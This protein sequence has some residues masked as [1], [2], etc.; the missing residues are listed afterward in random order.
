MSEYY[1]MNDVSFK[2]QA[3]ER[4]AR[5]IESMD[6][7][8]EDIYKDKGLKGLVEIEGVGQGMAEKIEEFIKTGKIKE[9]EKLK[10]ECPVDL[11]SLTAVE[12]LG[13]KKI[14][15]L[16]EKLG[17]KTIADLKE[18]A[19]AGKIRELPRFGPKVEENILSGI[20][21]AAAGHG[22]FLLGAI[23]PL[24]RKIEKRIAEL[25]Y[26]SRAVAAGSIRRFKETIGDIDILTISSQPGKVME[27]FCEMPEVEK[28]IAKGDT[29]SS[30]RLDSGVN[31]DIR[32]VPPESFGA[33]LQYFTGGK[34]HNIELRK[35]AQDKNLKLN[36]YGIFKGKKQVAGKT[37][38][39]VY[40]FLG[41]KWMEPELRENMGE[42]EASQKDQLPKLIE[43]K[44]ILGDLQ[45]HSDWSD[46]ENSITEMAKEASQIGYKYIAITDHTLD[47][48]IAG[49]LD[50]KAILKYFA[51][52][53]K[54]DKELKGIRI[55]KGLEVNIRKD[56]SLDISDDILAQVDIVLAAAHSNFKMTREEQTE[57]LC[58]AMKNPHVDIIAHP[59]GRIIG[60]RSGYELDMEKIFDCAKETGTVLEINSYPNRLDLKDA[61][62]KRAIEKG[63]K[64][65]LGTDSHAARQ[66]HNMELGVAQARRGWAEKK[67]IINAMEYSELIEFLKS[68]KK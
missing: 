61:H 43:A 51:E 17:V 28:V 7:D 54:V 29:K 14:K 35:I 13:P 36:E 55:L 45:M 59:T 68:H 25:D 12:G 32:V 16:Y 27:Y 40:E 53:E 41:L 39:D 48:K 2:P 18:A 57:R 56:G 38:E 52:I 11:E 19:S 4:A 49:G 22:R 26:V 9:Y 64:L 62:I 60:G 44:D 23:L 5:I 50:E 33:A 20:V 46:G 37:E 34:D 63:I 47:L 8:L 24:V 58:R 15:T 10:K 66:L 3:Y 31:A 30:V 1:V 65:S 6:V 67:D 42:I 21:F